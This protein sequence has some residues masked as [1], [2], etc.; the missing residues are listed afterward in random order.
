MPAEHK[1]SA[2]ISRA[3][4]QISGAVDFIKLVTP[5]LPDDDADP[6]RQYLYKSSILM[7]QSFFE[8]YLFCIVALATFYKAPAVRLHLAEGQRDP[9]RFVAMSTPEVMSAAQRRVS[10]EHDAR[11]LKGLF[12]VLTGGSPFANANCEQKCLDFANVRNIIA[13]AGGW[14]KEGHVPTVKSPNVIVETSEIHGSKF[15]KLQISR[16]FF[17]DSLLALHG[18][19]SAVEE[20]V[21][22]DPEFS[23]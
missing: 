19:V 13:H 7:V 12:T 22:A 20:R 23:L 16:Q 1:L 10:F 21:E 11:Q 5:H 2:C 9:E 17:G 15:F 4:F 18:S 3:Q 14:P 6:K 8:E